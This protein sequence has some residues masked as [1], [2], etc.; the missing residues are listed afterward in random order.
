MYTTSDCASPSSPRPS[1]TAD[2]TSTP[3][4]VDWRS[5]CVW[6]SAP[7]SRWIRSLVNSAAMPDHSL[8]CCGRGAADPEEQAAAHSEI[9]STT[10]PGRRNERYRD[11][12]VVA[13]EFLRGNGA[14]IIREVRR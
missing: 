5:M 7:L 4:E 13:M 2:T 1:S 12:G 3:P 8:S 11:D 10:A 14:G 9:S 6:G